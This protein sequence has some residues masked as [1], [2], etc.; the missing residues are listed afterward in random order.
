MGV[1][2]T[3]SRLFSHFYLLNVFYCTTFTR[4]SYI[5]WAVVCVSG[6]MMC[7]W[8]WLCY[9]TW[10]KINRP[11]LSE[12]RDTNSDEGMKVNPVCI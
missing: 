4:S 2:N 5:M 9:V 11:K 1:F 10:N 6:F 7:V 12:D 8:G 3:I